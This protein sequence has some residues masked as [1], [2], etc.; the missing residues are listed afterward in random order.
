MLH[1]FAFGGE[2]V[3]LGYGEAGDATIVTCCCGE[4]GDATCC[5]G[6]D[7]GAT[8][9]TNSRAMNVARMVVFT[10]T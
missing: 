10:I 3:S 5:C 6:E 1:N 4:A 9:V 2:K 8:I 7:G